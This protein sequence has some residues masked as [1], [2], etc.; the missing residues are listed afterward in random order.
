MGT[1]DGRLLR[2]EGVGVESSLVKHTVAMLDPLA[3]HLATC[4][5]MKTRKEKKKNQTSAVVVIK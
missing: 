2:V 3:Q 1:V 5:N 4:T